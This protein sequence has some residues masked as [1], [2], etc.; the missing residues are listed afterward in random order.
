MDFVVNA[1]MS[2]IDFVVI[3]AYLLFMLFIGWYVSKKTTSF[4][5][6]FIAGRTMTT[7]VLI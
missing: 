6:F 5:E 7:P 3:V 4:E 2:W 1:H